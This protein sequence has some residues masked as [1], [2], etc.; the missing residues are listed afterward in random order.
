M[1][2]R[3]PPAGARAGRRRSARWSSGEGR[4]AGPCRDDRELSKRGAVL[5]VQAA[6]DRYGTKGAPVN[7][8]SPGIMATDIARKELACPGGDAM[9]QFLRRSAAKRIAMVDD[10]AAPVE[11]LAGPAASLFTGAD[12]RAGTAHP[13][14]GARLWLTAS[15]S[16]EHRRW[17]SGC[18]SAAVVAVNW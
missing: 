17:R 18:R 8:V 6:A 4:R 10:I 9:R 15:R 12:Q 14:A 13:R 16:P 5:R 1:R 11:F 2:G 3:R 7:T